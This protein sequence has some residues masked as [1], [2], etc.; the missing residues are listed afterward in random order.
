MQPK[1]STTIS[2]QQPRAPT[3][4]RTLPPQLLNFC[5]KCPRNSPSNRITSCWFRKRFMCA[6]TPAAPSAKITPKYKQTI[7]MVAVI[8]VI[9]SLHYTHSAHMHTHT[10][11]NT[12]S[13]VC[14]FGF[15]RGCRCKKLYGFALETLEGGWGGHF[16]CWFF[17]LAH[18]NVESTFWWPNAFW[19]LYKWAA[20]FVGDSRSNPNSFDAGCACTPHS[21][22]ITITQC[23][24]GQRK[25]SVWQHLLCK[26]L[27]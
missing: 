18:T 8:V 21:G 1:Q 17:V 13:Q 14:N 20:A 23:F 6:R 24:W 7:L 3:E 11:T 19:K 27:A 12:E 2:P 26:R 5:T 10:H 9:V 16:G 4:L 22:P 15:G 25:Q